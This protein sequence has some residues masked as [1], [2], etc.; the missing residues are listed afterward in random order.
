M[1]APDT[2][3]AVADPARLDALHR[4]GLLDTPPEAAFDRLTS[5]AALVLRA[6]AAL[7]SLVDADR[8]FVKSCVG[9][10]DALAAAR[11]LPLS[12]SIC[13]HVVAAAAPLVV[14][15]ARVH[16]LLR[17]D[18]AVRDMGVVAYAGVPL[19]TADGHV[20]GSFCVVDVAPRAWTAGDVAVL[21]ELAA[22]TMT[23]V[24]LRAEMTER[25]RAEAALRAS[26]ERF[27][28]ALSAT[29]AGVWDW[30][31]PSGTG[32]FGGRWLQM[33]GYAPGELREHVDTFRALL[34]PDD[35]GRVDAAL[36]AHLAGTGPEYTVEIR[37]RHRTLGWR[38]VLTRGAVVERDAAGAP[39]RMV[40]TNIDVHDRK[41]LEAELAHQAEHDALTGL[42]NRTMFHARLGRALARA[43]PARGPVSVLLLDLDHFK[44]VND[45]QGHG[46]GDELL[47]AVAERLLSA[48]RGSD[49]VARLGGDEFAVLLEGARA[50]DDAAVVVPRIR[51]ALAQ[52]VT[53]GGRPVRVSAS[54]GVAAARPGD[55][56]DD[57]LRHAD[58]ALYR[59]KDAGRNRHATFCPARDA[60]AFDRSELET[61][62]AGAIDR[63]ELA[64]VYQPIVD[65][66]SGAPVGAEALVRWH[67]PARGLVRPDVFIPLAEGN[68]FMT[69]L[70]RWI[71]REA[72]REAAGWPV[73]RGA[74]RGR[75]VTLTVNVSARQ[76]EDGRF[77]EDVAE[78]LRDSGL[79]PGR[80]V[81]EVTESMLLTNPA[82][83]RARLEAVRALG[84][85]VAV[86]DFGTG[87]SSLTSV[88]H[89]PLDILK[90][91]KAFT[92]GLADD[93]VQRALTD[94]VVRLAAALGVRTVA[95]GV[96]TAEERAQLVALGC[97]YGQGYL[98][99]RP[100]APDAVRAYLA[101][102][103]AVEAGAPASAAAALGA[104]PGADA[105]AAAT[106][107]D[108]RR[109][110]TVLV[111][112]DDE[113]VRRTLGRALGSAGYQVL[114]AADGAE[115]LRVLAAHPGGVDLVLSDVV[116]PELGGRALAAALATRG[117]APQVLLMSGYD[118][119]EL[120]GGDARPDAAGGVPLLVKPIGRE[121]LLGAVRAAL[122]GGAPGGAA[123]SATTEVQQI[124]A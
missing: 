40:G 117:P 109:A 119:D 80:L 71:L 60:E 29:R 13:R 101:G 100:L 72:C 63:G 18:G 98:Y 102:A 87:Y 44:A 57:V 108:E 31:L 99:A 82:A 85:R 112:D 120:A 48:T 70:G 52:A 10:P 23:E 124:A 27:A 111:A 97:E 67:H 88:R 79:A 38:W 36:A 17:D 95:E 104:V 103:G 41:T 78:A 14:D 62:L 34:H 59:A 56:A 115:A 81:L 68:G 25:R 107:A 110:A 86:D 5:I 83:S 61:E 32:H 84:A 65:L 30:H 96:E 6:P 73:P 92:Q 24:S 77:V 2:T 54:I 4:A 51:D 74:P 50:G 49:T 58:V 64:L 47:V 33:L 76:L 12:H 118:A 43:E 21:R 45:S 15:D 91:D 35:A 42:A 55:T 39:V 9:L 122:A 11:E 93:L 20:L 106:P 26:D 94:T 123:G 46:A 3:A 22:S 28:L 113:A 19:T 53:V 69:T 114:D 89:L 116:M 8:Q 16:P 75:G 1:T 90:I 37:M 66:R 7:V 105:P 121:A